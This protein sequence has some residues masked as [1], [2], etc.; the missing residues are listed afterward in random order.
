MDEKTTK[1]NL[2]CFPVGTIGRDMVYQMVTNYMMAFIL[3]AIGP[4]PAQLAAITG[5][6]IAMRVFDAL[7]DPIMGNIIDRTRTKW[8][9]FKPW[10]LIG[11]LVTSVV[12]ILMF[13]PLAK[14]GWGFVWYFG[15]LYFMYSITY[16]M[17]DISYWGMIPSLGTDSNTR[18]KFT[19]RTNLCAGIGGT[20]LT[21]A[22]PILTTGGAALGGSAVKAYGYIA[23]A[24]AVIAPLFLMITIF[25][26]REDRS[27]E[28]NEVPPI[29][30]K[31]IVKTITGNDQLRWIAIAFLC[32]QI[33]NGLI[34][35]GLGSTYI[36]L[37]FGY[38]GGL[39]STF[40]TVGMLVTAL[41]MIFYP[42]ISKRIER[43]PF[44]KIMMIAAIVGYAIMIAAGLFLPHGAMIKFW[45]I[46]M[47]FM[48]SNFGQYGFYLIM[49]ISILN[50]VEYNEYKTG[51]RDD[52]IIASVRPLFTKFASAIFVGITNLTYIIL[53]VSSLTNQI[54]G[55]ETQAAEN[56]ISADEKASLIEAVV[57]SAAGGQRAGLLIVMVLVSFIFMSLS[58]FIYRKHYTLDEKEFDRICKELEARK[59]A[60][61]EPAPAE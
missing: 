20:L 26:V 56:L 23:M 6:M 46:T 59:G 33:G 29:S 32:Q 47:G 17:H 2:I 54:Q 34:L 13:N 27:Y 16:T 1:K 49:M 22:L 43:K 28:K 36:Y 8:G 30:F 45:I 48:I 18:D 40:S 52:A 12:I 31:K 35:G 5:I 53:K 57:Q 39:Y 42:T 11:I 15:I 25:G 7:N 10:F 4:T 37:E 61:A 60:T 51:V 9:K 58:Y 38:S 3:F 55:Y 19:S 21:I 14:G 41:L 50:T 24:L 44:M